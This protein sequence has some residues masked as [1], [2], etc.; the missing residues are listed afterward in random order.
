MKILTAD[1]HD[2]DPVAGH[3]CE[4][5][6]RNYGR[7]RIFH[8]P[9]VTLRVRD[10]HR[11][12]VKLFSSPGQG[13]VLVID[14]GGPGLIAL[15]GGTMSKRAVANGWAGAIV[16]G[17][18]R[19]TDEIAELDLGVKALYTVPRKSPA[20][21]P[22]EFNVPVSFGNV[23][24][25]PGDWVYADSDGVLVRRAQYVVPEKPPAMTEY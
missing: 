12:G 25:H 10:D 16:Y 11:P 5:D 20:E 24:F 3:L 19:D 22:H 15:L 21:T 18:I 7:K 23:T 13:R 8:G 9:C 17:V 2:S 1:V 6:F 14:G 4:I